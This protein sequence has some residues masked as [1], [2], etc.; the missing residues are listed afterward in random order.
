MERSALSEV[1]EKFRVHYY[2]DVFNRIQSRELPVRN[3]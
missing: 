2:K 1:Y 3:V